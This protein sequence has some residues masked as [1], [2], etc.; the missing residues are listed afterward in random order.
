MCC[1]CLLPDLESNSRLMCIMHFGWSD[2]IHGCALRSTPTLW[3]ICWSSIDDFYSTIALS[4]ADVG[5]FIVLRSS[6]WLARIA[7]FWALTI[8]K[9]AGAIQHFSSHRIHPHHVK[10]LTTPF[11]ISALCPHMW[12]N[13]IVV[14][15]DAGRYTFKISLLPDAITCQKLTSKQNL[16]FTRSK[17]VF[18]FEDNM[19]H[20]I[21]GS[22]RTKTRH[23]LRNIKRF[24][25]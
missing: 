9:R 5:N 18:N 15:A 16:V 22:F 14:P 12:L 25:K 20:L 17:S 23:L 3:T 1:S 19:P 2:G 4:N 10:L 21:W 7:Y 13:T 11:I 24:F 6:H 8:S